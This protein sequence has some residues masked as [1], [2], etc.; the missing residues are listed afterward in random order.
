MMSRAHTWIVA[1]VMSLCLLTAVNGASAGYASHRAGLSTAPQRV[2]P[3]RDSLPL[4]RDFRFVDGLYK[5]FAALQANK[6]DISSE[7]LDGRMVALPEEYT[8]KVERLFL[9]GRTDLAIAPEQIYALVF[10]GIPYRITNTDST[11]GFSVFSGLRVRGRLSY[12]EFD[13]VR[14]EDRLITAYVPQTGRPFRQGT[15]KLEVDTKVRRVLDFTTGE[16]WELSRDNLLRH[17]QDDASLQQAIRD[18]PIDAAP[19]MLYRCLL[20]YDDRHPLFL[21]AAF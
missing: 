1:Q 9:K 8:L 2:M 17:T 6:P 19:E 21:P 16:E 7:A 10:D 11:R 13:T 5:S 12:L 4:D 14:Y 18:L 3:L 20:I 15:V